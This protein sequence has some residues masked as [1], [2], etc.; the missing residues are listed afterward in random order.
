[1]ARTF[2]AEGRRIAKGVRLAF[3]V[4]AMLL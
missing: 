4:A 3:V 2:K 1:L